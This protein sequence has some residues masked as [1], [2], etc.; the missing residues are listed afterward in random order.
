MI[1]IMITIKIMSYNDDFLAL[2]PARILNL[3]NLCR[4]SPTTKFP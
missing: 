3:K 1:G 2:N 4:F